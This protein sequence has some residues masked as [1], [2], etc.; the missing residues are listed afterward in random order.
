MM[1]NFLSCLFSS[2]NTSSNDVVAFNTSSTKGCAS[3][4]LPMSTPFATSVIMIIVS[5]SSSSSS[6]RL[7][8]HLIRSDFPRYFLEDLS[9]LC[10]VIEFFSSSFKV[11]IY[12]SFSCLIGSLRQ[13]YSTRQPTASR[14]TTSIS[15]HNQHLAAQA[16]QHLTA[17]TPFR[18]KE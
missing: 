10:F 11:A 2:R 5:P 13:R 4:S 12:S 8:G 3:V 7:A 17:R 14:R 9:V 6:S 1:M 16:R 15:P 18:G